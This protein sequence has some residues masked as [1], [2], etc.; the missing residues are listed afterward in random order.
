MDEKKLINLFIRI[1]SQLFNLEGK[2]TSLWVKVTQDKEE[3]D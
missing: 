1:P 2:N 3:S